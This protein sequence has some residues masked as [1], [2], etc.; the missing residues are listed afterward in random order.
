MLETGDKAVSDEKPFDLKEFQ[1]EKVLSNNSSRKVVVVLGKCYEMPAII[2]L[3][4]V[5]FT[6]DIFSSKNDDDNLIKNSELEKI[7]HNDIYQNSFCILNAK[8]NS[9]FN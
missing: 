9:K 6:E 8:L 4:K 3:E 7:F 1:F 2:I 5:A